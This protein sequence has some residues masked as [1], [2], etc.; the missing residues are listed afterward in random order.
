ML[1]N[2]L[3]NVASM[4]HVRSLGMTAAI[5]PR[6]QVLPRRCSDV[7]IYAFVVQVFDICLQANSESSFF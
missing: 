5:G 2:S 4:A 3:P 7:L 6:F 1:R